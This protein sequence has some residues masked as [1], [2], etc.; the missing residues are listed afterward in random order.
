M[1]AQYYYASGNSSVIG[2]LNIYLNRNNIAAGFH[3]H[4]DSSTWTEMWPHL[5]L[6]R[7][8]LF[9]FL[10]L[11]IKYNTGN[12]ESIASHL[13]KAEMLYSLS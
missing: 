5:Q 13:T 11:Y 8:V 12:I 10:S 1:A 9:S 7:L 3:S 6:W 2:T 4:R